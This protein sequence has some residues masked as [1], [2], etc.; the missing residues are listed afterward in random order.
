VFGAS[1]GPLPLGIAYDA[2]GSYSGAIAAMLVL[3]VLGFA[4]VLLATPPA[5]PRHVDREEALSV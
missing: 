4:A 3:P 1:I 5:D 2:F